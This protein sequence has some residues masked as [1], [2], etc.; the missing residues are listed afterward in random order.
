MRLNQSG[1]EELHDT[2]QPSAHSKPPVRGTESM[3]GGVHRGCTAMVYATVCTLWNW[4]AYARIRGHVTGL[5]QLGGKKLCDVVQ[6]A[7]PTH[8]GT[9]QRVMRTC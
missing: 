4:P 9:A 2:V 1:E 6:Q 5:D 3:G 8:Y 7:C